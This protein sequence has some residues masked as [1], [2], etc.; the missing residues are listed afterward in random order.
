MALAQPIP[1]REQILKLAAH[2]FSE[3]GYNGTSM[4]D[5]A[6]GLGILRGSIYAHIDSK[7]DLLFEIVDRGADR[8]ITRITEVASSQGDPAEKL[9]AALLAH[10][11]TVAEH[12]DA[13]TVFLN[14][15]RLLSP[16]KKRKINN[17]RRR[18]ENVVES[19][20]CEGIASGAFAPDL[21]AR[22]ATL[23]FLSTVNWLYQ[24]Y[25]PDGQLTAQQVANRF[26][27]ILIQ[28]FTNRRS[29]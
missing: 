9:R 29:L 15:W 13:S 14:D 4:Q 20:I 18:Y 16:D 28:G 26:A 23:T 25:D 19:L 7:E 1:R 5:L 22:F 27:E 11:T 8:F 10:I 6:D 3:K 17:K 24:W 12:L 2:L 21:D